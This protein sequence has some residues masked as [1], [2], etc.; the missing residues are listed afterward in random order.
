MHYVRTGSGTPP[1]VFVHG[2]ACSSDDW[3]LQI[4]ELKK[5]FEIVACDL[6]GHGQT[7]GRPQECTIENFGGDVAALLSLLDLDKSFLVGHSMGCRVVLEAAR[8][9]PERIGGLV[10]IDGSRT[11]WGDPVA[12]EA[13]ARAAV[14]KSGYPAFAENLFRQMFFA[15][16]ALA[17]A[18]VAR[19]LKQSLQ[20]GPLLWPAMARWDAATMDAALAAVRVPVLVIQ[21]TTRNAEL[22]RTMLKA[23]ESSPYL[24]LLK[25]GLK[26]ARVEVVPETGHFTMLEAAERVNRLIS[27]FAAGGR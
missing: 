21:S 2:F 7:P 26:N 1:L 10:L 9:A 19:A 27:G 18:I 4:A 5:R 12:D 17:D 15:P 11:G 8:V 14:A 24:D 20:F 22:K 3:G 6:R 16:S 13:A 23:G 25:K